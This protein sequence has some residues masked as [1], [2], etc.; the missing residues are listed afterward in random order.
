METTDKKKEN[1]V[2]NK[3]TGI[4]AASIAGLLILF[5]FFAAFAAVFWGTGHRIVHDESFGQ[6]GI[7]T[8]REKGVHMMGGVSRFDTGNSTRGVVTNVSGDSFTLAGN[9]ATTQVKTSSST[10][11][12]GGNQVKV[13]DTVIAFGTS[14][15][16]TLQAEQIIINP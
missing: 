13:N 9:G 15:S 7:S 12:R 1:F 14:S 10:Q 4:V 11:Y 8:M 5:T 3:R 6:P 2:I 16:G